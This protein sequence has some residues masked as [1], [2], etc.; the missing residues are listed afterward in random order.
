[1]E[2]LAQK[3]LPTVEA[4]Q[5]LFSAGAG[6]YYSDSIFFLSVAMHRIMPK[7]EW[8][9]IGAHCSPAVLLGQHRE[10]VAAFG[11]LLLSLL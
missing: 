8:G 3:L 10:R 1:M 2:V 9:G 6:S 7:G 4:M 11:L 5:K